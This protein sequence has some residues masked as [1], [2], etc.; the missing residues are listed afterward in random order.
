MGERIT[1]TA[2]DGFTLNAYRA[3]PEGKPR[4]GVVVIQE[5]WGLNKFIRDVVDRYA[6][7]GFLAVAPAMFDRVEFGYESDDY[8]PEQFV[9][10]GELMKKFDHKTALLDVAAAIGAAAAGGKVGITG[11]C[12]G[13]AVTWRA[14]AHEGMGLSAASGYY[15]GGVPNYID[16]MPRIPIQMHYGDQDTGIPLEQIEALKARHPEADIYT[17]P[18]AHG[19]CNNQ[20]ASN[21]NEA[22]CTRASARTL[23]FFR[24]HLG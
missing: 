5:V 8:G 19:F 1:L 11:Y 9:I 10:I 2:S 21:F 13:G 20:R 14:A 3:M 6:R 12:F 7:H 15:G 24:Q 4:A 22:A 18:A 23:D 17:Y 16:L